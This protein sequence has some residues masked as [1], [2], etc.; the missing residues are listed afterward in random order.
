VRQY[1]SAKSGNTNTIMLEDPGLK[2]L[3]LFPATKFTYKMRSG[4][5]W[6]VGSGTRQRKKKKKTF[7]EYFCHYVSRTDN[8]ENP[9]SSLLFIANKK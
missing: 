4:G 1:A 9:Q 5:E 2:K 7:R 8:V 3:R 6:D